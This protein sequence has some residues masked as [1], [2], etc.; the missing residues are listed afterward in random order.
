MGT[1][2]V[3]TGTGTA[4]WVIMVGFQQRTSVVDG[5]GDGDTRR[6]DCGASVGGYLYSWATWSTL[7]HIFP[8][9]HGSRTV[10]RMR[11]VIPLLVRTKY[12][13]TSLLMLLPVVYPAEAIENITRR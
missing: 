5:C 2:E 6:A 7:R 10:T 3:I 8:L 1:S 9:R 12:H 11:T 13:C 4:L